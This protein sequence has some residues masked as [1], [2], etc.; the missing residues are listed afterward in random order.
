[1]RRMTRAGPPLVVPAAY[2]LLLLLL[3]LLL[4]PGRAQTHTQTEPPDHDSVK[5]E[6]VI[7]AVKV[8]YVDRASGQRVLVPDRGEDG[9]Y[10]RDSPKEGVEG[11]TV[12][13][14]AWT[15][16]KPRNLQGCDPRTRFAVPPDTRRWIA[17]LNR[18][19]CT[20]KQK[21]L[22]A[23]AQK[24]AAVVIYH[25]VSDEKPI[26]MSHQGQP[27]LHTVL[28]KR[29]HQCPVQPQYD[30]STSIFQSLSNEGKRAKH[31]LYCLTC[32]THFKELCT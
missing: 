6:L 20:F 23:A 1:M 2:L 3:L 10:G 8:S 19:N 9:R 25:N 18:G 32:D 12:L 5:G 24:A 15:P 14:P 31:H 21:I 26:T 28:Q 17:L 22:L 16:G 30:I 13:V 7:A 4:F 11:A 27:E 29:R